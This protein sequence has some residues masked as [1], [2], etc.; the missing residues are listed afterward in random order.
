MASCLLILHVLDGFSAIPASLPVTKSMF[1]FLNPCNRLPFNDLRANSPFS[2]L[3]KLQN[4]FPA[5]LDLHGHNLRIELNS[6]CS[7]YFDH[8]AKPQGWIKTERKQENIQ[9]LA[10]KKANKKAGR[11]RKESGHLS[12]LLHHTR[13]V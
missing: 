11:G 8:S 4:S 5:A 2:H 6:P 7:D 3:L 1:F 13:S 10:P 12:P 9:K